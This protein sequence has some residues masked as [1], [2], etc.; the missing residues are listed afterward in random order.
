MV[1]SS[2]A[3]AHSPQQLSKNLFLTPDKTFSRKVQEAMLAIQIER[4]YTKEQILV[5]VLQLG[6]NGPWTIP[7]SQQP[8]IFT[9]IRN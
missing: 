2:R 6:Y 3:E 9:S 8:Q 1:V 5:D 7:D 4:N